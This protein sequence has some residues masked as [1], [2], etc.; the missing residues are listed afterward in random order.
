[1]ALEGTSHQNPSFD[2]TP[3]SSDIVLHFSRKET[4]SLA[5]LAYLEWR[6]SWQ[7][8]RFCPEGTHLISIV[9]TFIDDVESI[10]RDWIAVFAGEERETMKRIHAD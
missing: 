2:G 4:P 7:V 5:Q 6:E 10:G 8:D 9:C 3:S 1:M